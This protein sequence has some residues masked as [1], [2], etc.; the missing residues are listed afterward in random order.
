MVDLDLQNLFRALNE[1]IICHNHRVEHP[2]CTDGNPSGGGAEPPGG[3]GG[4]G[5]EE[6]QP[7]FC[8]VE[9]G[10]GLGWGVSDG[11]LL[12]VSGGEVIGARAP[13]VAYRDTA[14]LS[15]ANTTTET[16]ILNQGVTPGT[17]GAVRL[18]MAGSRLYNP[19]GFGGASTLRVYVGG[20]LRYED[21]LQTPGAS[22]SEAPWVLAMLVNW[23]GTTAY[24]TGAYSEG[25]QG[26]ATT[27]IGD[28]ASGGTSRAF[29]SASFTSDPTSPVTLRVTIQ[30]ASAEVDIAIRRRVVLVETL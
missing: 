15:V 14:L 25:T 24:L 17:D 3:G 12:Q 7:P 30:H 16:D 27:G 6:C 19:S 10:P 29:G 13:V 1:L 2:C 4:G 22:A 26:G 8:P 21:A 9:D 11:N 5:G 28:L 23:S 20:T 18:S